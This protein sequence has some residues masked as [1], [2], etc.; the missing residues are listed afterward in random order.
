MHSWYVA[1]QRVWSQCFVGAGAVSKLGSGHIG[2]NAQVVAVNA[3]TH[4]FCF[5]LKN[6]RG[7]LSYR[8]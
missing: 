7:H 6:F 1:G 8:L 4:N 3:E 5:P 2:P